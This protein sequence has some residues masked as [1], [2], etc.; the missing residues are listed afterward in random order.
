M[1]RLV[2]SEFVSVD[3]VPPPASSRARRPRAERR[4]EL[5]PRSSGRPN[6]S[7]PGVRPDRV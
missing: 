2:V 5:T 6:G 4:R 7:A 3:G 1:G